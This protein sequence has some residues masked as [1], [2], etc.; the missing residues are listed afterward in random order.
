M[1]V[2]QKIR[3]KYA[4]WIIVLICLAIVSF[5]L[6]DVFFGRSGM[7]QSNVVGKVNGEELTIA[8]YQRRIEFTT[9]QMRQ[10]MPGQTFDE[11]AQQYF[12]EEAWNGFLRENIMAKQYEALGIVVTDAEVVDAYSTNNPHPLVRQQFSNRETGAYDPSLIQQVNQAAKQDPNMRAQLLAFDQSIVEY[13]QNL[14]YYSLINKGI[15]YPKW[16]AKQQQEDAAKNA[17]IGY[18]QVPYATIADSTIKP[19]DSEL[20]KY[21]A[22]NKAMFEVPEGRKIE[23]VSFDVIPTAADSAAAFAEIQ[24]LKA[25]MDTTPDVTQF[26]KLN[27]EYN[28]YDGYVS[29]KAI[30]VPNKDSI[31]DLP[32]GASFGPYIDGNMLVYAKMLDR[33]NMADTVKIRQV[34]I[35]AQQGSDS[36]AKRQADS[37][38]AVVRGGGDIAAIATAISQDPAAKENGGEVTLAPHTD[39]PAELAEVKTFAFEGST[40]AVKTV[41][42]PIGYAVVKITEQKNIGPALKIAYLGKRVD[43]SSASSN[44]MLTAANEFAAANTNRTAFDKTVQEKGLNKRIAENIQPMDFVL[45]GL[46]SAR[47]IVSWAYS[48][49]KNDV[50]RVFSL[51]DRFVIA[52]LTSIREK[53]TAPLDE[54]R[55]AVEAEVRKLKKAEQIIAKLGTPANLD[56]AAKATNQPVLTAEGVNFSSSYAPALNFEPRVIGAAF[57][58]AWGTNKVSAPIQGQAGVFVIQVNNYTTADVPA[59][60]YAQQSQAFEGGI[61][62]MIQQQLFQS[63]LKK[64]SN[65]KD[66]RAEFYRGN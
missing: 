35:F 9:D 57:N 23:Y 47:E 56:A 45:P 19:T 4:V 50:S 2:I 43:A 39:V 13:Q 16:L 66:N 18:V 1:S 55:P 26:V 40:G 20:N 61:Q 12:R 42:L 37:V 51:E 3:D 6:Q 64:N 29:R 52:V 60:D 58:K 15:Y 24:K 59:L 63:V 27:S 5:L 28:Q 21:I 10:R 8:D 17:N 32:T 31:I 38:E 25:E 62:Q 44:D 14:K 30:Q 48:A 54:V 11:E 22:D 46:G 65:V 49:D 7:G 53:G 41:K 36:I 33:K 34:L